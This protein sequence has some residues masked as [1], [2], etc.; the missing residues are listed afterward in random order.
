MFIEHHILVVMYCI[1]VAM[2]ISE[3][4]QIWASNILHDRQQQYTIITPAV[5]SDN[6]FGLIE[7]EKFW[8]HRACLF[9]KILRSGGGLSILALFTFSGGISQTAGI[10][11]AALG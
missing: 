4:A 2:V 5:Y 3:V 11:V 10:M 6:G 9:R 1:F 7:K 8:F